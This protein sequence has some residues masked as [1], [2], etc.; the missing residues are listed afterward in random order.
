M[1][2]AWRRGKSRRAFTEETST[3]MSVEVSNKLMPRIP[4]EIEIKRDG[5]MQPYIQNSV[6]KDDISGIDSING[7]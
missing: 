1:N 7:A 6:R 4:F 3:G 2:R 5:S